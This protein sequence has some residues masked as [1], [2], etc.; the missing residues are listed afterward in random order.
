MPPPHAP[1]PLRAAAELEARAIEHCRTKVDATLEGEFRVEPLEPDLGWD[2]V[3]LCHVHD[4]PMVLWRAFDAFEV[5]LDADD[6]PVGFVDEDKWR[7][8]S[9]REL[10]LNEAE[11]LARSTGLVPHGLL[12]AEHAPG[13]RGCLVLRFSTE[14]PDGP[15]VCVRI[16]PE[17]RAV[18]SVEPEERRA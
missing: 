11:A 16:N 2:P 5:I 6:R 15:H 14:T 10:P 18:I 4:Q 9:W 1:P 3:F 13:E 8:C 17:R 7:S 12:L